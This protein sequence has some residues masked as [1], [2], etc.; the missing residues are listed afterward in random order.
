MP[1]LRNLIFI[2]L[3]YSILLFFRKITDLDPTCI[4]SARHNTNCFS[5]NVWD[6][7][8]QTIIRVFTCL[9]SYVQETP[10]WYYFYEKGLQ[11]TQTSINNLAKFV[12]RAKFDTYN[13][14]LC[15]FGLKCAL[16][17]FS[18]SLFQYLPLKILPVIPLLPQNNE[19][20]LFVEVYCSD[21]ICSFCQTQASCFAQRRSNRNPLLL[22]L[23]G[24]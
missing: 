17:D 2:W 10:V 3:R 11:G 15:E 20:P 13:Q 18:N 9:A 21:R 7:G 22:G 1:P 16:C 12:F 8:L 24:G 14:N 6:V 4:F 23:S 5:L 19:L